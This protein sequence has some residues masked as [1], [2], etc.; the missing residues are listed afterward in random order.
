VP[1]KTEIPARG[2]PLIGILH[3]RKLL[4]I[5]ASHRLTGYAHHHRDDGSSQDTKL[6]FHVF[7][8]SLAYSVH[9]NES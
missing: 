7:L 3:T 1:R 8:L 2:W 5:G 4:L 6:Y 9:R